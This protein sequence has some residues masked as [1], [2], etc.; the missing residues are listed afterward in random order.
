MKKQKKQAFGALTEYI[1]KNT[2]WAELN[3]EILVGIDKKIKELEKRISKL[4]N[5][6]K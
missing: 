2:E 4:E 1:A 3:L 5:K 6:K